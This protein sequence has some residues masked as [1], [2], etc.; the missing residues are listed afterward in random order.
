MKRLVIVPEAGTI[1]AGKLL[2]L[3][4]R[5]IA[6]G[7][8]AE[9]LG[10]LIDESILRL[11]R[12]LQRDGDHEYI[13][14][15]RKDDQFEV[16]WA[17]GDRPDEIVGTAVCK[18]ESGLVAEVYSSRSGR[19]AQE[20]SLQASLFTNLGERRGKAISIMVGL[21]VFVA[22]VCVGVLT[23]VIYNPEAGAEGVSK[24]KE[25][26]LAAIMELSVELKIMKMCLGN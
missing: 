11:A 20:P 13:L 9:Q 12:A 2:Q 22:E 10:G 16:A 6:Q 3:Q 26:D 5:K 14:W 19:R 7:I 4:L 18:F 15:G 21:P 8:T 24:A 1:D 25:S 17:S 23:W